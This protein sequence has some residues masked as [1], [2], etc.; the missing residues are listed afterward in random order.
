MLNVKISY[1]ASL[2]DQTGRSDEVVETNAKTAQSLFEEINNRYHFSLQQKALR[3]AINDCFVDW[4]T[5]L[6]NNDEVVFI[7]PVAGG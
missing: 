3:V 6:K 7:P 4:Q 5:T 2:R 1:F